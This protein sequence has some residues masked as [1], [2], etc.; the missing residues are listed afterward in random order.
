M[1]IV[2]YSPSNLRAV[3]QQSQAL[4]FQKMGHEP[5]LLTCLP[6]GDLHKN[7]QAHGFKTYSSNITNAGGIHYFVKEIIFLIKFC[8]QFEID[9]VCCHLQSCALI[10]G[11]AKLFIRAKV[12]YMRHH[13]DFVGIY[14]SPKE[15]LQNWIA[16]ILS[17]K[18][19][20]ISNTVYDILIKENVPAYKI[21]RI[22]LCYDFGEYKNDFTD[23]ID[24]IKAELSSPLT[25]LY[26]A[27]LDPVKRHK[28]A[29]KI[30]EDLL[31]QNIEC[32]LF[33]IGRGS[34]EDELKHYILENDLGQHIIM[35]G[36]VT[37]VFDYISASDIILLLS[38]TEASSHMLKESGICS[39]TLIA[40]AGVGDFDDYIIH[41]ENG[42]LVNKEN[43]ISETIEILKKIST[44]KQIVAQLGENL[45]ET[46][47]KNFSIES[48][49]ET[50]Y[51]NLFK[52]MNIKL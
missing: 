16:N 8:K 46:V 17:P 42:Y 36:F 18:I 21:H 44:N 23:Q 40:C 4:L 22:N 34:L 50:L 49:F 3:D 39:K 11:F 45:K 51:S 48:N 41:G 30:V 24:S 20:A 9:L 38:D 52:S 10:A 25:M 26:V 35:K 5:M 19:I 33:C 1:K 7:F 47:Y 15:R 31:A 28:L 32:K 27:R 37:N 6:E 14:N 2:I 13:T 43:P 12:V 29:F